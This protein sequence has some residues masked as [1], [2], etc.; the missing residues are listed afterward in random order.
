MTCDYLLEHAL[1]NVWCSPEQDNQ[2][3]LKPARLTPS[4]GVSLAFSFSMTQ[5]RMPDTGRFHLFQIGLVHPALLSLKAVKNRWILFSSVCE[6]LNTIYDLYTQNGLQLARTQSWYMVTENRNLIIAVKEHPRVPARLGIEPLFLRI[7]QNHYLVDLADSVADFGLEVKIEGGMLPTL[8]EVV[9]LQ[10]KYE[11]A[12]AQAKATQGHVYSFCNGHLVKNISLLTVTGGDVAEFVYD[13]SITEVLDFP[14]TDLKM[15]TST[16]DRRGKY[17]LHPP[18]T[19][20]AQINFQDDVDVFL[21]DANTKKGIWYHKNREDALRNVTHRDYST[22]VEHVEQF[23]LA[24]SS[25]LTNANAVIRLHVRSTGVVRELIQDHA[26]V[27]ELYRLPDSEIVNCLTNAQASI[28]TWRAASLEAGAYTRL[29]KVPSAEITKPLVASAYGYNYSAKLIGK[30]HHRVE[31]APG[32]RK[33]EV[34]E[35]YRPRSTVLEHDAEGH[36]IG[37]SLLTNSTTYDCKSPD[38]RIVEFVF[39]HAGT[40]L[41][42]CVDKKSCTVEDSEYDYRLY[43]CPKTS[44]DQ[45]EDWRD[46]TGDNSF[47]QIVNG[48]LTWKTTADWRTISRSNKNCLIKEIELDVSDGQMVVTL[49][50]RQLKA[51]GFFEEKVMEVPL[52]ELHVWVNGRPC[53]DGVDYHYKFPHI[54]FWNKEFLIA[55]KQKITILHKGLCDSNLQLSD[56]SES[57]FVYRGRLSVDQKFSTRNDRPIHI[58]VAG[59]IKLPEDVVFDEDTETFDQNS[60]L[61]GKPYCVREGVVPMRC[62]SGKDTYK[63]RDESRTVDK[64]ISGYLSLKLPQQNPT[65]VNPVNGYWRI[66]SPMLSKVIY[67]LKMGTF[68]PACLTKPNY[69]DNDI[70]LD[71]KR[72]ESLYL[73]DPLNPELRP[74]TGFVL[75]E[76][77]PWAGVVSV[78]LSHYVF[79]NKVVKLLAANVVNL[80]TSV[81]IN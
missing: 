64:E 59:S 71:L 35:A 72:Y 8:N 77:H 42:E 7:Y 37:W 29:M 61:N 79:L 44:N 50:N 17:L 14:V 55:G 13:S 67:D 68:L 1:K 18:K 56:Q 25:W 46:V 54:H 48:V 10:M 27:H 6:K 51:D 26:R 49:S 19:G 36:L 63:F 33:V 60:P 32:V 69:G 16:L 4:T 40:D 23:V 45:E 20:V 70:L 22:P 3:I 58:V 76:P 9:A 75:I 34:P 5:L 78:S 15:F 66:Y 47:Y 62:Q 74:N 81:R 12:V 39:G 2:V 11:A 52:G 38:A 24:H 41:D 57:G 65:D 21:M 31:A 53:I 73:V 43:A 28:S 80:A 30:T